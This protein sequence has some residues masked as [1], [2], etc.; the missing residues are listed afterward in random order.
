MDSFLKEISIINI[1]ADQ[2]IAIHGSIR[3]FA[4][5]RSDGYFGRYYHLL[6]ITA[7]LVILIN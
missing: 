6:M 5:D 4:L 7:I 3:I 2:V 1:I